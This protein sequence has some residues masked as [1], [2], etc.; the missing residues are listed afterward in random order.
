MFHLVP[1]VSAWSI[2][3]CVRMRIHTCI[4]T[5]VCIHVYMCIHVCICLVQVVSAWNWD[6]LAKKIFSLLKPCSPIGACI[7][8]RAHVRMSTRW[9][10][11]CVCVCVCVRTRGSVCVW[12]RPCVALLL[13]HRHISPTDTQTH[14]F[15]LN[16]SLGNSVLAALLE[17]A[18]GKVSLPFLQI[19]KCM[20]LVSPFQMWWVFPFPFGQSALLSISSKTYPKG[21]P[22]GGGGG[23]CDQSGQSAI[24]NFENAFF[25][26]GNACVCGQAGVEGGFAWDLWLYIYIYIFIYIYTNIYIYIYTYIYT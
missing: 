21:D 6:S 9:V 15:Y 10:C 18:L 12:E 3:F 14:V 13:T 19:W 8:V 16:Y 25:W 5:Y 2:Y 1:G 20:W 7:I 11:V 26:F 4:H 24:C 23:S 17:R 22:P